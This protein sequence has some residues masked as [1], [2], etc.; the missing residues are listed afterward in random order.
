MFNFFKRINTIHEP[1]EKQIADVKNYN[2]QIANEILAGLDCDALPN[3]NG[4]FGSITNPI[5]VNGLMG[6]IKYLGKLRGKTG[7]PIF[8]HRIGSTNS[9]VTKNTIDIFELVCHDSTQWNKLYLDP[10]HP[11]RSNLAPDGYVLIPYD[12]STKMDIPFAYGVN[13][14]LVNFP[15]DLP[16]AL[17]TFYGSTSGVFSKNAKKHLDKYSFRRSIESSVSVQPKKILSLNDI[18][19]YNLIRGILIQTIT[20]EKDIL[21]NQKDKLMGYSNAKIFDFRTKD[22]FIIERFLFFRAFLEW[23]QFSHLSTDDMFRYFSVMAGSLYQISKEQTLYF[24]ENRQ[25]LY[26]SEIDMFFKFK[27]PH[28]GKIMWCLNNPTCEDIDQEMTSRFE[29]NIFAGMYIINM[30][31]NHY[32]TSLVKISNTMN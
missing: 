30:I 6:E 9:P 24:M 10:Y 14:L 22:L 3:S 8:F 27:H 18:E 29:E 5:P 15:Y 20:L 11:R 13:S 17:D 21:T 23:S 1:I 26:L 28:P 2:S 32:K 16:Q 31:I 25:K 12:K 7:Y 19:N 4:N